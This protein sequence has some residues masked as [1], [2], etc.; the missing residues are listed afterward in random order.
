MPQRLPSD[1]VLE[2]ASVADSAHHDR[3]DQLTRERRIQGRL[4]SSGSTPDVVQQLFEAAFDKAADAMMIIDDN[5]RIVAFNQASEN[6]TGWRGHDAVG[7]HCW[8]I[9]HCGD[10]ARGQ[11]FGSCPLAMNGVDKPRLQHTFIDGRGDETTV[12]LS[13]APL[14]SVPR[15]T[16]YQIVTVRDASPSK[17]KR[18]IEQDLIAAASHEL[19]SPLNLIGGYAATLL[20]FGETLTLEQK[21]RYLRNIDATTSKAVQV[22][23][24]FLDISRLEAQRLD[25]GAGPTSL[26]ELLRKVVTEVQEQTTTHVIKL[27]QARSLPTVNADRQKLELVMTNLLGNAVKYSPQGNDIEV[28]VRHVRLDEDLAIIPG[29][30]SSLG[31]PCL[32]VSV[33]DSGIGIPEDELRKV[34]GKFHRVDNRLTH[35]TSG[36]GLGLYI[37]KVIVEAHGGHIWATSEFGKGTTINFALPVAQQAPRHRA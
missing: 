6:L 26:P 13:H 2:I 20:E 31:S 12:S 15:Q 22:V 34:F 32:I 7:R 36:T 28:S 23:R 16:P 8:D 30:R 37:C 17:K 10:E 9:Y 21:T 11:G 1:Q 5:H 29:Q 14:S 4:P 18:S 3:P 25:L 35:A 19:L 24:D 33:R 27:R